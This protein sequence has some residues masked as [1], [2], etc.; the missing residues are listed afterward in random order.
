MA[1]AVKITFVFRDSDRL[2]PILSPSR[3]RPIPILSNTVPIKK[4]LKN[5]K[6]PLRTVIV[7]LGDP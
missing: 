1:N 5:A 3:Y 7:W 2:V 4:T 6:E